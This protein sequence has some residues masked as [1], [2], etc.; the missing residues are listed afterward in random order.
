MRMASVWFASPSSV[1]VTRV[2]SGYSRST[3]RKALNVGHP[4]VGDAELVADAMMYNMQRTRSPFTRSSRSEARPPSVPS[5]PTLLGAP[6]SSRATSPARSPSSTSPRARR[7]RAT[8]VHMAMS[9]RTCSSRRMDRTSS[10]A[11]KTRAHG[12][13]RRRHCGC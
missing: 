9:S 4:E 10:R 12:C 8:S 2:R 7:S 5:P 3:A 1:W 11:P 13:T 6:S